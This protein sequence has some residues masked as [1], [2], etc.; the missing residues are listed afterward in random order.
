[1]GLIR[2]SLISLFS[3]IGASLH[4]QDM[5]VSRNPWCAHDL[6][7]SEVS[8]ARCAAMS[9]LHCVSSSP[10]KMHN[11]GQHNQIRLTTF[12]HGTKKLACADLGMSYLGTFVTISPIPLLT[13][14]LTSLQQL[15]C[16]HTTAGLWQDVAESHRELCRRHCVLLGL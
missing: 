4:V 6:F 3:L 7:K 5:D 14:P 2:L 10:R 9:V 16:Q 8:S 12:K 11:Q 13:C 15:T 1:M